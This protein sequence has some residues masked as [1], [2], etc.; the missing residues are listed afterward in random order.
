[1]ASFSSTRFKSLAVGK[2]IFVGDGLYLLATP[3]GGRSWRFQP[4]LG[5]K[6]LTVTLGRWDQGVTLDDARDRLREAKRQLKEG[7]HPV[8]ERKVAAAKVRTEQAN[9]FASIFEGWIAEFSPG[10]SNSWRGNAQRW[11]ERFLAPVV[12]ELPVAEVTGALL[13]EAMQRAKSATSLHAAHSVRQLAVAVLD[14]AVGIGAIGANP[15]RSLANLMPRHTAGQVA[16]MTLAQARALARKI[17]GY[18]GLAQTRCALTL[19]LNTALRVS[20]VAHIERVWVNGDTLVIPRTAMKMKNPKRG[21]HIVPLSKQAMAA[22][23]EAMALDSSSKYLFGG[24]GTR[25]RPI[26][27]STFNKALQHMGMGEVSPH[28]IRNAFSTW[29]NEKEIAAPE[30]IEAALDHARGSETSR[31]YNRGSLLNQRRALMQRW[32]KELTQ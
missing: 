15:A 18:E 6:R 5:G 3:G 4:R 10:R 29:A 17:E 14:R 24:L 12:G 28:S 30:V 25:K 1:M 31:A 13:L 2:S 21:D 19:M 20:E 9:T 16:P 7:R 32:S 23:A 26:G 22:V 27:R 8:V 11:F